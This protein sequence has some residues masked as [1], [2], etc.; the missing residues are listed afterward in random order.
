M[1]IQPAGCRFCCGELTSEGLLRRIRVSLI[2]PVFLF[3]L[4][5]GLAH[6]HL[7]SV[8]PFPQDYEGLKR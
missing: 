6:V 2:N 4:G 5:Q 3:A 7:L 1:G 8:L